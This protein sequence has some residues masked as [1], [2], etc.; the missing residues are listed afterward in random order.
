MHLKK[1]LINLKYLEILEQQGIKKLIF[2]MKIFFSNLK[3]N[4]Q[5]NIKFLKNQILK[6][7]Y[8]NILFILLK[9]DNL[10]SAEIKF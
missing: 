2:F 5:K 8:L 1:I 7:I 10:D 4:T 3:R 6:N 9:I